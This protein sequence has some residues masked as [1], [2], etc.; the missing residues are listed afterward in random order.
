MTWLS[1]VTTWSWGNERPHWEQTRDAT[2]GTAKGGG[3]AACA[4]AGSEEVAFVIA[5]GDAPEGVR[6][7]LEP[8][9]SASGRQASEDSARTIVRPSIRRVLISS[10]SSALLTGP[11]SCSPSIK[12]HDMNLLLCMI[13]AKCQPSSARQSNN[14]RER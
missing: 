10:P 13:F 14:Y 9:I 5:G 2:L 4:G 8:T 1:K 11:I 3:A 6:G 7:V 12:N